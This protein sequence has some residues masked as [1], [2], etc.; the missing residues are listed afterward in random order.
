MSMAAYC[1]GAPKSAIRA[2]N[3]KS[4]QLVSNVP[5]MAC[6]MCMSSGIA[7]AQP[8]SKA[9]HWDSSIPANWAARS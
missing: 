8:D 5:A 6:S 1:L 4:A 3:D 2:R 9:H 7:G